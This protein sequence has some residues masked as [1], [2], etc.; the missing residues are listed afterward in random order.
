MRINILNFIN[1]WSNNILDQY[2]Q[3][4]DESLLT[5]EERYNPNSKM[6]KTFS[7]D[8]EILPEDTHEIILNK[9][10]YYLF[11]LINK[12]YLNEK[13]C[14]Y[15][16]NSNIEIHKID[17]NL[18]FIN[19]H[20]CNKLYEM[21]KS[22]DN[23]PLPSSNYFYFVN[24]DY[25]PI[26]LNNSYN[27]KINEV[28]N[29]K[30]FNFNKLNKE[31]FNIYEKRLIKNGKPILTE[32]NNIIPNELNL[33]YFPD[34]YIFINK[35]KLNKKLLNSSCNLFWDDINLYSTFD[36]TINNIINNK[37]PNFLKI[38]N[39]VY[40]NY[41]KQKQLTEFDTNFNKV[42]P[43]ELN[44]I[45]RHNN[46]III[47]ID[48][49][50]KNFINLIN[51][52][53]IFELSKNIPFCSVYF[54]KLSSYKHKILR[55]LS[56][57][58]YSNWINEDNINI[59]PY[60]T[61]KLLI[62][63]EVYI[64]VLINEYGF[65]KIVIPNIYLKVNKSFLKNIIEKINKE[66][67]QKINK[68]KYQKILYPNK[69][70]ELINNNINEFMPNSKESFITLNQ[71]ITFEYKNLSLERLHAILKLF[72]KYILIEGL[73]DN[74]INMSFIY[75]IDDKFNIIYNHW[76][77][78]N[79]KKF[80]RFHEN[81]KFI[82][83]ENLALSFINNFDLDKQ[84]VDF[85]IETWK[86]KNKLVLNDILED[87]KKGLKFNRIFNGILIKLENIDNKFIKMKFYGL[88]YWNQY[89]NI[90]DFFKKIFSIC[91]SP[92]KYLFFNEKLEKSSIKLI[93][94]NKQQNL[95]V[96]LK[97]FLPDV[98]WGSDKNNSESKGFSRY[99]QKKNQ[100][101]IFSNK[102]DYDE[103]EEKNKIKNKNPLQKIFSL[104]VNDISLSFIETELKKYS[105][106]FSNLTKKQKH[107]LLQKTLI[108][109]NEEIYTDNELLDITNSLRITTIEKRNI[110]LRNI[111]R[112]LNIQEILS[113][114]KNIYPTPDSFII[115]R[116]GSDYYI[117]CPGEENS[118]NKFIGFVDLDKH[119][120]FKNAPTEEKANYC[121]PCCKKTFNDHSIDFC[122]KTI[123][124]N[125]YLND[126]GTS[127]FYIKNEKKSPLEKNRFGHLN[128][129]LYTL[130]NKDLKKENLITDYK[131][132][133]IFLRIG[134]DINN[135][136]I[137]SVLYCSKNKF[138]KKKLTYDLFITLNNGNLAYKY[139][140]QTYLNLL[141]NDIDSLDFMDLWEFICSPNILT[142]N[143]FNIIIFEIR[144]NNIYSVCPENQEINYFYK[145]DLETIFLIKNNNFFEPIIKYHNNK[146]INTTFILENS[147]F[148]NIKDWYLKTCNYI[149]EQKT[150]KYFSL[151]YGDYL[152]C[153]YY[154][155]FNKVKYILIKN[156][157]IPVIPCG[158]IS[159][160]KKQKIDKNL[161]LNTFKE[162][163]DFI[164]ENLKYDIKIII[165]NNFITHLV[166]N[167][168]LLLPI[169]KY[170]YSD[171]IKYQHISKIE[172][173]TDI[174][175]HILEPI[176]YSIFNKL[177]FNI[178]IKENYEYFKLL[179]SYS[180]NKLDDEQK[181]IDN[182]V[183]EHIIIVN[184]EIM[185]EIFLNY[186][187]QNIRIL[188]KN[189]MFKNDK[190]MVLET[191]INNFKSQLLYEFTKIKFKREQIINKTLNIIIDPNSFISMKNFIYL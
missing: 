181:L 76:L 171:K 96:A 190:L 185:N 50:D 39:E 10:S 153:Q 70:L 146:V 32:N 160:L 99:C 165:T 150:I 45:T 13:L 98:F 14:I 169:Q 16:F 109:I 17:E 107:I 77:S 94:E 81:I 85:I 168:N 87:T 54:L 101:L 6:I 157:L 3:N 31:F 8:I 167:E 67:I 91:N 188:N 106:P 128:N 100:P 126:T 113:K 92:E 102:E 64:N 177:K 22:L 83:Y 68:I 152:K 66:I 40:N 89:K 178:F 43:I 140:Y 133:E 184:K 97:K 117:T 103:F 186:N 33:I 55:S 148:E 174:D 179:F 28:E 18:S 136:F 175:E 131:D 4:T 141:E 42:I 130:F 137:S 191:E 51:I 114:T 69:E 159:N 15:C 180:L 116:N 176:N 139:D 158:L 58:I 25:E 90:M 27:I 105:I 35:F 170:K 5:P 142:K 11:S 21:Y 154:N 172:N 26:F 78:S 112:F 120:K 86:F 118:A 36:T 63:E 38:N 2:Y 134:V 82:D 73:F 65:I 7:F 23:I 60:L 72:K 132:N 1:N 93:N 75:D 129:L 166:L 125:E 46:K 173:Y 53:H 88:K 9:I 74:Y 29:F 80:I 111:K 20:K 124:Y 115:S 95:K 164:N 127:V 48:G 138:F 163:I 123:D 110:L 145:N 183:K 34:F 151:E 62:D 61:F 104:S 155:N 44:N 162:A 41:K 182:F 144:D 156:I 49:I 149:E 79:I 84:Q 108:E 189:N 161:P 147:V 37:E 47:G 19:C 30:N 143:G 187:Y 56:S 119:P 135:S 59:S 57:D 121:V 71:I 122:T 24:K 12:N 52:F